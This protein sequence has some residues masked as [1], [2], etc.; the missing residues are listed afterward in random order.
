MTTVEIWEVTL[1]SERTARAE[2]HAAVRAISD[3]RR[4]ACVSLSHTDGLALVAVADCAVGVDVEHLAAAP[5]HEEL[6]DLA[7]LTLS[8]REHHALAV[9]DRCARPARWLKLWTRKEAALKAAGT[10]LGDLAIRDIDGLAA[11]V[12]ELDLAGQYVGAV[13]VGDPDA[14]LVRRVYSGA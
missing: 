11:G 9:V 6:D 5:T 4:G 2:S 14:R 1:G 10:S 8:E 12:R 13:A 3:A 7:A